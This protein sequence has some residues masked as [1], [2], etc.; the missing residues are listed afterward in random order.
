MYPYPRSR[1]SHFSRWTAHT[2]GHPKAFALAA[3][4]I[5]V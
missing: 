5:V 3:V 2:T 4:T 1:F